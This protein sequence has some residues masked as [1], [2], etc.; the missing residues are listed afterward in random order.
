M[1]THCNFFARQ[2]YKA[3]ILEI[4]NEVV[5]NCATLFLTVT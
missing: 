2:H 3:T 4:K 1:N 5:I